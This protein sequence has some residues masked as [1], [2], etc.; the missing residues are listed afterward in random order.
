MEANI[1]GVGNKKYKLNDFKCCGVSWPSEWKCTS[2]IQLLRELFWSSTGGEPGVWSIG[3]SAWLSSAAHWKEIH[4]HQSFRLLMWAQILSAGPSLM[5]MV[6][7]R[8]SSFRSSRACPS[9]SCDRNWVA[10]SSQPAQ[11]RKGNGSIKKSKVR[12]KTFNTA[13]WASI[14]YQQKSTNLAE[15]R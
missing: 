10:K 6:D 14:F 11:Q 1:S 7:M 12:A 8:C 3:P 9:I 13:G 2:Y 15:R 4:W 5:F